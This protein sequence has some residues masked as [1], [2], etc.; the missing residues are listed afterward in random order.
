MSTRPSFHLA[1]TD[2][3]TSLSVPARRALGIALVALGSAPAAFCQWTVT[4]LHPAGADLSVA[5]GVDGQQVVGLV[6]IGPQV[7]PSLWTGTS[8]VYVDLHPP[9]IFGSDVFGAGDGQQAGRI[10][11]NTV[12]GVSLPRAVVWSGTAAS[13]VDLNPPSATR[14]SIALAAKGGQQAGYIRIGTLANP[15]PVSHAALWSGTANS[16]VDLH[17]PGALLSRAMGLGDG[18]QVGYTFSLATFE[19]ACL[20]T[21]TAASFVSLHPPGAYTS[22]ALGAAGGQQVGTLVPAVGGFI[23]ACL[24]TGTAASVVNLNPGVAITSSAAAVAGGMQVGWAFFDDGT[25]MGTGQQRAGL[26]R[27]TAASWEDLHAFLP[28]S[29]EYSEATGIWTDGV[30]TRVCGFGGNLATNRIECLVWTSTV[31]GTTYC[32]AAPNSTGAA[33]RIAGWGSSVVASNDFTLTATEL[34]PNSNGLFF[35][36]PSQ[37]YVP[38]QNGFRCVG[39]SL[40]RILPANQANAQGVVARTLDL[41]SPALATNVLPGTTLNFQRWYRDSVGASA[42]YSNALSV[43]WQ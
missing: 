23:E 24:W 38:A 27:G 42:N 21:G 17:P 8:S 30:T 39:G 18:Q 22:Q 5:R 28:S 13:F 6:Q 43:T 41:T 7:R 26:W 33:S 29:F 15:S 19:R 12:P 32:Q 9:G 2:V 20:W 36:G 40:L 25:G 34:P 16:F 11:L 35:F 37:V 3:S 1:S 14:G 31:V 4:N 10:D